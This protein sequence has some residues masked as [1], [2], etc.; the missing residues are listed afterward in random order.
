MQ[1]AELIKCRR[2]ESIINDEFGF[3][4]RSKGQES[5]LDYFKQCMNKT[6]D[7]TNW[8]AAYLEAGGRLV[9]LA[10][11]HLGQVQCQRT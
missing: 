3:L 10:G 4:D 6:T 2:T 11:K 7:K 9:C 1:K 8:E 5:F